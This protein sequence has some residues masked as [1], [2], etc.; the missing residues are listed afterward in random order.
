MKIAGWLITL[1]ALVGMEA[2]ESRQAENQ[3]DRVI[4]QFIRTQKK[5][6]DFFVSSVGGG[7]WGNRV[8][9][10]KLGAGIRHE[11]NVEEAR[12]YYVNMFL[13]FVNFV[14]HDEKIRPYLNHMPPSL[15]EISL[16]ISFVQNNLK[17]SGCGNVNYVLV[18]KG[19][20]LSFCTDVPGRHSYQDL[21]QEQ[22]LESIAIVQQAGK[23]KGNYPWLEDWIAREKAEPSK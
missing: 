2:K 1:L 19:N 20:I 11:C 5:D 22:F 15:D 4:G 8:N 3:G 12:E 13:E 6:P 23:L 7:F 18:G 9:N 10:L 16:S 14:I 21:H 17:S